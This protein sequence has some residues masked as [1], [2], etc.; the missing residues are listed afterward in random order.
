[1]VSDTK[2]THLDGFQGNSQNP[3]RRKSEVFLPIFQSDRSDYFVKDNRTTGYGQNNRRPQLL[4][5]K[6]TRTKKGSES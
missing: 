1:M 2:Q 3:V 4:A 6:E 5:L